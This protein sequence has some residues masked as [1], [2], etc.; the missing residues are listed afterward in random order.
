MATKPSEPLVDL[1]SLMPLSRDVK[2]GDETITITPFKF[3]HVKKVTEHVALFR[4]KL[5]EDT[6]EED[7]DAKLGMMQLALEH[8][9]EILEVIALATGRNENW[10]NELGM[11]NVLD[12][13]GAI[14]E[15][16]LDFF[17]R[18]LVPKVTAM[19]ARIA[20]GVKS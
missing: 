4:A 17:S 14:I 15:V 16:N 12:L 3:R 1:D 11:D 20:A 13:L 6:G 8:T 2:V 18:L 5:G 10:C 19:S 7:K 9:S